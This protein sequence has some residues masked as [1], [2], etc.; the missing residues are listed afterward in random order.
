MYF[1]LLLLVVEAVAA[2]FLDQDVWG[3]SSDWVSPKVDERVKRQASSHF[4]R[5]ETERKCS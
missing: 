2:T 3:A 1:I 5:R 4:R